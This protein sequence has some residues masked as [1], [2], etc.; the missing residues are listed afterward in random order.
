MGNFDLCIYFYVR[1]DMTASGGD[2]K[3]IATNKILSV[4][5]IFYLYDFSHSV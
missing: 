4:L 2:A 5:L 3:S 1:T